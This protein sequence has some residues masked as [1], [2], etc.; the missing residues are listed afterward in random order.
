MDAKKA[1]RSRSF[2]DLV[3]QDGAR[4]HTSKDRYKEAA[5]KFFS[6]STSKIKPA[7]S[8]Y[9]DDNSGEQTKADDTVLLEELAGL[10]T[11]WDTVSVQRLSHTASSPSPAEI[12]LRWLLTAPPPLLY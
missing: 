12:S 9:W 4:T 11:E 8:S 6:K 1:Y 2:P 7:L 5:E 3:I 10:Q